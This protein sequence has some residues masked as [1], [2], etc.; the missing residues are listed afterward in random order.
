[1]SIAEGKSSQN[2]CVVLFLTLLALDYQ[3]IIDTI[4]FLENRKFNFSNK[5]YKIR[6]SNFVAFFQSSKM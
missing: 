6:F 4:F 1:M 2:L 5:N 3:F